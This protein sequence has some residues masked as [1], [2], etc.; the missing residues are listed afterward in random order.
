MQL[1]LIFFKPYF[2]FAYIAAYGISQNLE[3]I[4]LFGLLNNI[5]DPDFPLPILNLSPVA[6]VKIIAGL[7]FVLLAPLALMLVR[8]GFILGKKAGIAML[9][10]VL[11]PGVLSLLGIPMSLVFFIPNEFHLGAGYI[12][13]FWSNGTSFLIAFMW[14]WAAIMMV[15]NVFKSQK[16]KHAYDHLWCLLTLVGCM[17]LV[18]DSQAKSHEESKVRTNAIIGK[19]LD[20]Y[21][22]RY[23]VLNSLCEA[24]LALAMQEKNICERARSI[25]NTLPPE[26]TQSKPEFRRYGD[27]WLANIPSKD[28]IERLNSSVCSHRDGSKICQETPVE[29]LINSQELG[30][31]VLIPTSVQTERLRRLYGKLNSEVENVTRSKEHTHLKYFLFCVICFIAG[32]KAA[33]SSISFVGENNMKSRSWSRKIAFSIFFNI[34]FFVWLIRGN[35]GQPSASKL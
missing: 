30:D 33:T 24:N 26:I 13:G 11:L 29:L 14:G 22:D 32:G 18:V 2:F 10:I 1:I 28:D 3:G 27:S 8:G 4:G 9:A 7:L 20:F 17:Y 31:K 34:W 16:F 35:F 6:G 15:A 5:H 25:F 21:N 12:G 23:K 19:Y